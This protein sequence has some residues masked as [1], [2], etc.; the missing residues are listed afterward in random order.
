MTDNTPHAPQ[1]IDEWYARISRLTTAYD[2]A[3]VNLD[4]AQREYNEWRNHP[5]RVREAWA[6]WLAR[7]SGEIGADF[8]IEHTG[9][10]CMAVVAQLGAVRVMLTDYDDGDLSH[11]EAGT[12]WWIGFYLPDSPWTGHVDLM[13]GDPDARGAEGLSKLVA[14]AISAWLRGERG[15]E[16][17][18]VDYGVW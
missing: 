16:P 13:I 14:F 12:G 9:G 15:E 4:R 1:T 6:P 5:E 3:R 8:T 7:L 17:R 11:P 2:A 18:R 10:G